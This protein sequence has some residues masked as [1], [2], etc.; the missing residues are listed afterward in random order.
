M[1]GERVRDKIA[2]FGSKSLNLL[3]ADPR[4]TGAE[5]L[6]NGEVFEI[7]IAHIR[8]SSCSCAS[9]GASYL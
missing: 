5:G 6:P 2:E 8:I 9:C 1:I 7:V 3:F 4:S